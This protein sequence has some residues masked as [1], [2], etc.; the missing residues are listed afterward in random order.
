MRYHEISAGFQVPVYDEEQ[1]L[2]DRAQ[3][4]LLKDDLDEREQEVVRLMIS[5]G[6]LRQIMKDGQVIYRPDSAK[7]I[8]R[9]RDG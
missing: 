5:R 3:D 9:H 4:D 1:D 7:D 2:L 6:L 8:W